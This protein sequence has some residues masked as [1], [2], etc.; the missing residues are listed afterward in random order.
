MTLT[1][2]CLPMFFQTLDPAGPSLSSLATQT[3]ILTTTPIQTIDGLDQRLPLA[4]PQIKV[5]PEH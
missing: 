2:L 1:C 3:P 4:S 5:H